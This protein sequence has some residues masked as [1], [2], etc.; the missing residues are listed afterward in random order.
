VRNADFTRLLAAK[1]HRPAVVHA[2]AFALRLV[3]RQ[4]ADE[5]LLCSQH[6]IPRVAADLGYTFHHPHLDE[7]LASL[8]RN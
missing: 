5:M 1:V 3:M 8:I 2:P 6:A 4:M 7:A